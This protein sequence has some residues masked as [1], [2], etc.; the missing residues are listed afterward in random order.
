VNS[1]RGEAPI[2]VDVYCRGGIITTYHNSVDKDIVN[3]TESF[4]EFKMLGVAVDIS[5]WFK[6]CPWLKIKGE[7]SWA[8][9]DFT[10]DY[11]WTNG[12]K[13]EENLWD[14]GLACAYEWNLA[15]CALGVNI[16]YHFCFDR[17]RVKYWSS[18]YSYGS[19]N[20]WSE[21][22]VYITARIKSK[23][24]LFFAA[25]CRCNFYFDKRAYQP[26][27]LPMEDR[28]PSSF[29]SIYCIIGYSLNL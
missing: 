16:G 8:Y 28:R 10:N 1:N 17:W 29:L 18:K 11:V 23:D 26:P 25:E 22:L 5:N 20:F 3:W 4:P 6:S 9:H 14:F 15:S 7:A 2:S 27:L 21:P 13:A 19:T 24:I 12:A